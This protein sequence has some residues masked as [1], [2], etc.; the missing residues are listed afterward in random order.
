MATKTVTKTYRNAKAA[1][2]ATT[3]KAT[4]RTPRSPTPEEIAAKC[5]LLRTIENWRSADKR[6]PRG[7]KYA[8]PETAGR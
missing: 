8:V 5:D 4:K 2:K 3:T 6:G 7:G 1:S